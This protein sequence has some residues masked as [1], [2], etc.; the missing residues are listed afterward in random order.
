MNEEISVYVVNV[1]K[2]F[3][4]EE[5]NVGRTFT[6]SEFEL[7]F[8]SERINPEVDIIRF[9]YNKKSKKKVA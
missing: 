7:E 6:L 5:E 2:M 9:I 1:N 3:M 4:L 8:N